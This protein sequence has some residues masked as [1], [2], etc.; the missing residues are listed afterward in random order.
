MTKKIKIRRIEDDKQ[1]NDHYD[2]VDAAQIFLADVGIKGVIAFHGSMGAGKTTFISALCYVLGVDDVVNSP[3]FTI[4]NE[5]RDKLN[6][7]VYH[8]DFYRVDSLKEAIDLGLEEYLES[9][10]L[11]LIEWPENIEHLLNHDVIHVYI[12]EDSDGVRVLEYEAG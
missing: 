5:Y 8:F 2:I 7:P 12:S 6:N 11:S 10:F 1:Q 9:G 3:T 4:V